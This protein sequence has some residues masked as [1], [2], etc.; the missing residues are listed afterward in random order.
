MQA[1]AVKQ[2]MIKDNDIFYYC[3]VLVC[4]LLFLTG[5]N[6]VLAQQA[7][8]IPRAPD[9]A[10]TSY[11]LMDA[12]TG[13][14]LVESNAD[15]PLPPA[16]LTKIMTDYVVA[17]ELENGNITLDEEV[18]ISVKAW[19]MDGSKNVYPGRHDCSF[20]RPHLWHGCAVRQ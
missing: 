1:K 4:A 5:S 17:S 15:I 10:A 16:S 19:Q 2:F 3:C 6:A 12:T 20:G 14:I 9:I 18:Y 13:D 11:V 7:R 8:I